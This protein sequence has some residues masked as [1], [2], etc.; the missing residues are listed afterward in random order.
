[1]REFSHENKEA[2]EEEEEEKEEDIIHDKARSC[3]NSHIE[4]RTAR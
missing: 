3:E 1:M 4:A 2:E